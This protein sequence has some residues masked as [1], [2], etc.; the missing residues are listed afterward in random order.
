MSLI[1]LNNF[2]SVIIEFCKTSYKLPLGMYSI[3]KHTLGGFNDNPINNKTLGCLNELIN[4]ASSFNLLIILGE[5]LDF[6]LF[7]A[8]SFPQRF[9][10][11]T[12]PK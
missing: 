6:N 1:I 7:T 8:T 4:A 11:K 2:L 12:S 5:T 9:P 3:T 10:T